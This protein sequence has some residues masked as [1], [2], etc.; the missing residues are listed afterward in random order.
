MILSQSVVSGHLGLFLDPPFKEKYK[1]TGLWKKEGK[2]NAILSCELCLI[3]FE[4][5]GLQ[6]T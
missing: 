6:N 2:E 5:W 3:K 4:I 1:L